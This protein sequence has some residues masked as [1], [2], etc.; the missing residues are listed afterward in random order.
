MFS[1]W[2][3]KSPVVPNYGQYYAMDLQSWCYVFYSVCPSIVNTHKWLIL[4]LGEGMCIVYPLL[5]V[6]YLVSGNGLLPGPEPSD[7]GDQT[8]GI[9]YRVSGGRE[10]EVYQVFQKVPLMCV[11]VIVLVYVGSIISPCLN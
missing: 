6:S 7:T 1:Y 11:C 9:G 10:S 5:C 2:L 3:V 4:N 8:P